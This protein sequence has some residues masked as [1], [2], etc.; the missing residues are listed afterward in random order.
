M[1]WNATY[2]ASLKEFP[3]MSLVTDVAFW[4]YCAQCETSGCTEACAMHRVKK[5]T[6]E[7]TVEC[8]NC[9]LNEKEWEEG[10]CGFCWGVTS[11]KPLGSSKGEGEGE[12][13]RE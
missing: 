1:E 9:R 7:P 5:N 10:A 2:W 13:G 11:P 4:G 3:D 12:Q 8:C 6:W